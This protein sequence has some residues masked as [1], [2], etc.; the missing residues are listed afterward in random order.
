MSGRPWKRKQ[1]NFN[2]WKRI[3]LE[4]NETRRWDRNLCEWEPSIDWDVA[5]VVTV[6]KR[7]VVGCRQRYWLSGHGTRVKEAVCMNR[8]LLPRLRAAAFVVP[9]QAV[10]GGNGNFRHVESLNHPHDLCFSFNL[11]SLMW[12]RP[13][14]FV[15]RFSENKPEAFL[16][17]STGSDP[18]SLL[19][20]FINRIRIHFPDTYSSFY[21]KQKVNNCALCVITTGLLHIVSV[22]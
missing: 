1:V 17:V 16:P 11:H 22:P 10:K 21:L 9:A 8:F 5:M 14:D 3:S 15:E 12:T 18:G 7:V 20:T 13:S 19:F 6:A 4:K 2:K